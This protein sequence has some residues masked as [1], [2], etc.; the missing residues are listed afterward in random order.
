MNAQS[1]LESQDSGT[2]LGGERKVLELI[3]T[4]APLET[5]LD[6]LCRVIDEQSGLQSSI[7]LLDAAGERLT[8]TAGPQLPDTLRA[9][10]ASFPVTVTACGAAVT[11]REQ[12]ISPD[13][14]SDPLYVGF[15]DAA[16]RAN[17]RAVWSTPFFS[18]HDRPLGTFAVYSSVTGPPSSRNLELVSHAT[19]LASIAVERHQTE[20]GLRES[21]IRFSRAF[22]ANP[23]CM[24]IWSYSDGRFLLVNDA[25]VRMFGY[26]RAETVGQSATSLGLYADPQQRSAMTEQLL[27]STLHE[28]E[29]QGRKKSGEILDL[30]VSMERIELLGE[31]SVL[32]IA[33]DIT[34]R[35]RAERAVRVSERR[36]RSVFDNSAIGIVMGDS[37]LRVTAAN[38]ALQALGGYSEQQL[39][40]LTLF[41]VTHPDDRHLVE[42]AVADLLAGAHERQIEKRFLR[43]NGEVI[44]VR[45][46]A[47]L[48]QEANEPSGFWR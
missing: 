12:I 37:T 14:A 27:E 46:T 41:D 24:V 6:A 9:A 21:E 45:T 28:I 35:K 2:L 10:V 44:W 15:H 8:L 13:I 20:R 36:W 23:A 40:A 47:S 7:F 39:A 4:G 30:I 26:S 22:Y 43:K 33:T 25:F 3:A 1:A 42:R 19:H 38:R 48:I 11:R 32:A 29:I 17:I 34:D 16:Q 31:Q 18:K 5:I